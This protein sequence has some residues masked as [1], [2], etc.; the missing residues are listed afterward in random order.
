MF[1]NLNLIEKEPKYIY[2]SLIGEPIGDGDCA[3]YWTGV[4][5]QWNDVP[6][7]GDYYFI[8]EIPDEVNTHTNYQL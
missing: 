1:A 4:N 7:N 3:T 2:P 8:C 5:L 6:C